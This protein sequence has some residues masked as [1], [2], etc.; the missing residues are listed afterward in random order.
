[1]ITVFEESYADPFDS[2]F[3]KTV[4]SS[5]RRFPFKMGKLP[6]QPWR[7]GVGGL[8]GWFIWIATEGWRRGK[9]V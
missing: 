5:Y 1:M 6:Y 8:K 2:F 7:D 9:T 3:K 4:Y